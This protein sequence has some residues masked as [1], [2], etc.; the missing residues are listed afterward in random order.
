MKTKYDWSGVPKDT[1]YIATEAVGYAHGWNG[2]PPKYID[3]EIG[4]IGEKSKITAFMLH[5]YL[6]PIKGNWQ[7]SLEERPSEND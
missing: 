2:E 4:W 3:D 6:N 5:P 7:D 1:R